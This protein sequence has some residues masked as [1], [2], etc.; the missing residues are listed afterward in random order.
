MR[1]ALKL[2]AKRTELGRRQVRAARKLDGRIRLADPARFV[3]QRHNAS[4]GE[5]SRTCSARTSLATCRVMGMPVTVSGACW[6]RLY[7][8][9]PH[10]GGR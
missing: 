8:S 5:P 3:H 9:M 6:H 7:Q 10:D 4:C 1:T 2:A